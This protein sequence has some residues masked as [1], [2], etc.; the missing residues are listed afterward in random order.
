MFGLREG[1][2]AAAKK[3]PTLSSR[4]PRKFLVV[5][6]RCARAHARMRTFQLPPPRLRRLAAA[7]FN[8][9]DVK[10]RQFL[11]RLRTSRAL[12]RRKRVARVSTFGCNVT[13][14]GFE[15]SRLAFLGGCSLCSTA[16]RKND[17]RSSMNGF[18][19]TQIFSY[20]ITSLYSICFAF[21]S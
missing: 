2:R 20:C 6:R 11:L 21:V 19:S 5:R 13:I 14:G 3:K 1:E 8:D 18:L 4:R 10:R 9:F 16:F 7:A 15:R 17:S 12:G